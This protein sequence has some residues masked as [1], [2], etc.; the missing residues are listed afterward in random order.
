M[1]SYYNS[2]WEI[3]FG[4]NFQGIFR[5]PHLKFCPCDVFDAVNSSDFIKPTPTR[6]ASEIP[7]RLKCPIGLSK[8]DFGIK[9]ASI[10]PQ[11]SHTIL[12]VCFLIRSFGVISGPK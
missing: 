11:I 3:I 10:V 5:I 12:L 4:C 6:T 9:P 8:I 2:P 7:A 1:N